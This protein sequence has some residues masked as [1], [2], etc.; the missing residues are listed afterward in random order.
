MPQ[1]VLVVEDEIGMRIGLE[2]N[3]RIAGYEVETAEDGEQG[4]QL[5]S[6]GKFDIILLDLILPVK[7]GLAVCQ[8]L[9]GKGIATPVIMVTAKSQLEERLRGFAVG[10]DDYM[11]KPF[12]FMELLARIRV[13]LRRSLSAAGVGTESLFEFGDVRVDAKRAMAIRGGERLPLSDKEYNLLKYFVTHPSETIPRDRLLKEVWGAAPG[14]PTRTVDVH[15]NLLRAKVE[16]DPKN[17]RWIRSVYGEGYRF[18]P[19]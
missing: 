10:A 9:R 11:V 3:L 12:D 1:R 6:R 18:I 14:S 5:A 8:E 7:D 17:P 13:A 2:D 4:L 19:D 16:D 15:V